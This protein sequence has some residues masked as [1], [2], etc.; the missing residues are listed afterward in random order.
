MSANFNLFTPLLKD[1]RGSRTFKVIIY[2]FVLHNNTYCSFLVSVKKLDMN[3]VQK[4]NKNVFYDDKI[5]LYY[6]LFNIA[7]LCCQTAVFSE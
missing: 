3:S 4:W 2:F 5:M 7:F 6:I 1:L